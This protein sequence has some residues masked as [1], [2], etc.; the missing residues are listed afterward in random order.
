MKLGFVPLVFLLLCTS[1]TASTGQTEFVYPPLIDAHTG[2][3]PSNNATREYWP[4]DGWRNST[5]EA[6]GMD[7]TVLNSMLQYIETEEYPIDSILIIKN[8]YRVLEE[9]PTGRYGVDSRHELH[10]VTKSFAS[11]LIGIAIQQGLIESVDEYLLDFFPEYTPA[12]PDRWDLVTIKH[13]LTM[14]AG[15]EWDES[16]LPYSDPEVNDIGGIFASDDGVQFVL[17]KPILHDPGVHW[18]YSGGSSLLL[19]AIV[20]QVAEGTTKNF[21]D[22]YL[23]DP[24][25]FDG[26]SWFRVPGNWYN[27]FGGQLRVRT[28]DLAKLGFLYLNNG[29]WNGSQILPKDYV[30]NAIYPHYTDLPF[31]P[32]FTAYGWQWWI[33]EDMETFAALGRGGQ[34]I[35]VSREHDMVVVFTATIGDYDHDPEFDLFFSYIMES[36]NPSTQYPFFE[37]SVAVGGVIC[38]MVVAV[39]FYLKRGG[40]GE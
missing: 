19:G 13:L 4:T 23:F 3:S 35:I 9:Y 12:N 27:T 40:V 10:S 17:D 1:I 16:T 5:P 31:P 36:L 8:G 34:K 18:H 20:Q 33:L 21:A 32:D 7:S 37:I 2:F 28:R 11:T 22:E 24:L 25:G 6:E 29:T 26:V 15:F 30:L 38:V 39:V 14:S